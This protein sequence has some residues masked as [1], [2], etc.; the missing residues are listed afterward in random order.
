LLAAALFTPPIAV[1]F[2]ATYAISSVG[3]FSA[4]GAF[5]RIRPAW[6]GSVR[7]LA[8][9]GHEAPAV[10]GSVAILLVSLAGLP[11]LLGFWGKLVVFGTAINLASLSH[12]TV[13]QTT[14]VLAIG[15]GVALLG[16]V[17]SLGYYGSILRALFLD[18]EDAGD[19]AAVADAT[20]A[21]PTS[22]RTMGGSAGLV[23]VALAV[24]VVVAGLA[25]TAF[26]ST[27]IFQLFAA[28]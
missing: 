15:V 8:G 1:F 26:G 27:L 11:P 18:R 19:P 12:S 23:V 13:P 21:A 7:G 6:D 25:T 14:W 5:R 3:T 22:K 2:A 4:A 16:S 9:L 20:D 17:I 24:L 28:R 10:G